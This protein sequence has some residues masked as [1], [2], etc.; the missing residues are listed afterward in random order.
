[1]KKW[2]KRILFSL[3]LLLLSFWIVQ[4]WLA[5]SVT[6]TTTQ[7]ALLYTNTAS[8]AMNYQ[9]VAQELAAQGMQTSVNVADDWQQ[10]GIRAIQN[11]ASIVILGTDTAPENNDLITYAKRHKASLFF[12]GNYPGDEY[13]ASYDKAYFVGSRMEYAS[14]LAGQEIAHAFSNQEITDVNGNLLLDYLIAFDKPEYPLFPNTLEECEHYGVYVQNCLPPIP[15]PDPDEPDL[16]LPGAPA[17]WTDCTVAPELILCGNFSD[18]K[19]AAAWVD[20][21]GWQNVSY[22]TFTNS[23]QQ[24]EEAADMGCRVMVYYDTKFISDTVTLLT[25]N[26]AMHN[27]L[28]EGLA[29]APDEAGAFWVPYQ[30]YT[31]SDISTPEATALPENSAPADLT[32]SGAA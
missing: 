24:A 27:S 14:E 5:I 20:E 3:C 12:V 23:V 29:L 25:H 10:E 7:V 32:D 22:A 8:Y 18:F 31:S 17:S 9:S 15:K 11:G 30:L 2:L 21:N 19:K 26:L 4:Q 6:D 13:L 16:I 1:M 28:A